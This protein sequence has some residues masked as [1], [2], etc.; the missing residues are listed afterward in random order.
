MGGYGL[1]NIFLLSLASFLRWKGKDEGAG[2]LTPFSPESLLTSFLRH[3]GGG[4]GEV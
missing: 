4:C 3:G 1:K 2:G